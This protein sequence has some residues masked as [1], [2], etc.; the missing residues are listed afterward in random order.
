MPSKRGRGRPYLKSFPVGA[1]K[2]RCD[3]ESVAESFQ[4]TKSS[5]GRAAK[6]S[7]PSIRS[8]KR[9][10]KNPGFTRKSDAHSGDS[11]EFPAGSLASS[12]NHI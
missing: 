11:N 2:S 3:D 8:S 12:H 1:E 7:N 5:R 10:N 9:F 6:Y 4:P